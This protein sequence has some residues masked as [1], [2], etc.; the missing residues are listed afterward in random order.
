MAVNGILS[1]AAS[2]LRVNA[3]KAAA[4]GNNIVNVNS[5]GFRTT[6]VRTTTLV[7]GP[8]NGGN[9]VLAQL[10]AGEE[11]DLGQ[12]LVRLIEADL[13]YKA[14]AQVLGTGEEIAREVLDLSA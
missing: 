8:V 14:N 11:P 12:E 13:A 3:A 5:P 4:A 7:A 6:E 1:N 10:A 2:G 9:G